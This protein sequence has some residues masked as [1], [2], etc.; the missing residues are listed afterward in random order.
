[1]EKRTNK[2]IF[3]NLEFLEWTSKSIERLTLDEEYFIK[4]YLIKKFGRILEAGVG[5]GRIIFEI[6][7]FGFKNI[8][9][10]D[11]SQKMIDYA[12]KKKNYS[13]SIVELHVLDAT[14]LSIF[15]DHSFDYTL[16]LQQIISFLPNDKL[17]LQAIEEAYRVLKPKGI[18][19]FSF[20]NWK[21]RIYNIPLGILLGIIRIIINQSPNIHSLPWLKIGGK[22]N[23]AF[24]LPRQ[25]TAYWFSEEEAINIINK[26]GFKIEEIKMNN[27]IFMACRKC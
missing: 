24:I 4:K 3:E 14:D 12:T 13:K 21:G 10:Y 25:A 8:V 2:Y 26:V 17:R 23:A 5:G 19:L 27:Y 7:K 22:L 1:M 18:A 9:G 6:E 11:F 20:L 15:S 16:Y